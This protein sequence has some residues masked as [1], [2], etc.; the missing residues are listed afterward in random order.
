MKTRYQHDVCHR[1]YYAS[2]RESGAGD[3]FGTLVQFG[4]NCMDLITDIHYVRTA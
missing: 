1:C 4:Q 2:S 3:K